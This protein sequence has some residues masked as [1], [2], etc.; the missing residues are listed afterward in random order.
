MAL[1]RDVNNGNG[2]EDP[3]YE[4]KGIL[5]L[6]DIIEVILGDDIIDE[7]DDPTDINYP[8]SFVATSNSALY[9]EGIF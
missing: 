9:I 3:F 5:T 2:S 6:E 7:T 4:I 8:E 1:D